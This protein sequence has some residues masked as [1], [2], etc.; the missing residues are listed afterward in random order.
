MR[1]MTSVTNYFRPMP[2][3]AHRRLTFVYYYYFVFLHASSCWR[4]QQ[5]R[6]MFARG[7]S[8]DCSAPFRYWCAR[9]HSAD[10]IIIIYNNIVK[11]GQ[12]GL[13]LWHESIINLSS[14]VV[15]SK[16]VWSKVTRSEID[17]K[18]YHNGIEMTC[19]IINVL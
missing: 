15:C 14:K 8:A 19:T 13:V 4:Q 12:H 18:K 6:T 3:T 1:C 9:T 2:L 11:D 5:R 17:K 16:V 10:H 7:P